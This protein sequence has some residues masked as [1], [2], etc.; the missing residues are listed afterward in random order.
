MEEPWLILA[1]LLPQAVAV[2]AVAAVGW[3]AWTLR[4]RQHLYD[5]AARALTTA[6]F[7]VRPKIEHH[8][9]RGVDG[10]PQDQEL[11][12]ALLATRGEALMLGLDVRSSQEAHGSVRRSGLEVVRRATFEIVRESSAGRVSRRMGVRDV[13]IG[14]VAFDAALKVTGWP[15]D[16]ARAL[17]AQP[18]VRAQLEVLFGMAG[19]RGVRLVAGAGAP[20]GAL[21]IDWCLPWSE[22]AALAHVADAAE[23]LALALEEARWVEPLGKPDGPG[24]TAGPSGAASGAPMAIPGTGARR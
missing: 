10:L 18:A 9:V 13:E 2:T 4:G 20:T 15:E 11:T 12:S 3:R 23:R 22:V 5:G 14:D 6:G 16:M 17:V 21:R 8:S 24:P 1:Q 19:V 7:M